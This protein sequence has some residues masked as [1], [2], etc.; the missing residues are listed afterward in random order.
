MGESGQDT[1]HLLLKRM[2]GMKRGFSLMEMIIV[3]SIISILAMMSLPT[4][5][6]FDMKTRERMLRDRLYDMRLAIDRYRNARM[7][8]LPPESVASLLDIIPEAETRSRASE[9]P[10]LTLGQTQNPFTAKDDEFRW[11]LRFIATSPAM[12]IL[13]P[14]VTDINATQAGHRLFDVQFPGSDT[15]IGGWRIAFD[16]TLYKDW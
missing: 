13:I 15:F 5:E 8:N 6:L 11:D 12:D 9:G 1:L 10:F 4:V 14:S 16:D 2:S 3:V 7:D